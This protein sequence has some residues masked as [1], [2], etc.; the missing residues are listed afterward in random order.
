LPIAA[1]MAVLARQARPWPGG[2][3][4][5][6]LGNAAWVLASIAVLV[7]MGPNSLGAG[8]LIIQAMVVALFAFAEFKALAS[9][10]TR[11]V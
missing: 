4:L 6:I 8:F 10:R 2:V 3:W 1:F 9:D 7:V 5:V 11:S